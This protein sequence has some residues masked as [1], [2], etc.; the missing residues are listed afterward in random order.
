MGTPSFFMNRTRCTRESLRLLQAAHDVEWGVARG[1]WRNIS[2]RVQ[3]QE[4][5]TVSAVPLNRYNAAALYR[6]L[7]SELRCLPAC[8]PVCLPSWPRTPR[9]AC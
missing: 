5:T 2:Q 4:C 8:L 7:P 1:R 6:L 9:V 3:E